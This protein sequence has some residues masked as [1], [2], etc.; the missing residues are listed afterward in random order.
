MKYIFSLFLAFLTFSSLSAQSLKNSNDSLSHALGQDLG[1]YLKSMELPLNK[2]VLTKAIQDMLDG[3]APLFDEEAN[4]TIIRRGMARVQ[5]ERNEALKAK[6]KVFLD[7]NKQKAGVKVTP[8]GLQYQVIQEGTGLQPKPTDEV[9]VHYKGTLPDGT[10]FDNSYDRNEPIS[11]SLDEV[12]AGW[13]IG[14]P[15]MKVGGKYR[16]VVPSDLGYG[17]R[18][19]GPIPAFSPLIFE[20]ELLKIVSKEA[21]E[22]I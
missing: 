7:Q 16:F 3:K 9:V 22:E 15:L 5:D 1:K 20:V 17:E 8:E 19:S 13:K 10:V 18:Q 2:A 14:I 11:I 4:N 12:I 6:A 21:H